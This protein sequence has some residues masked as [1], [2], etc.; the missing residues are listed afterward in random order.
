MVPIFPR[1]VKVRTNLKMWNNLWL[2]H[3]CTNILS[4][5]ATWVP[6][7]CEMKLHCNCESWAIVCIEIKCAV[8]IQ[9]NIRLER[10]EHIRRHVTHSSN[11]SRAGSSH[12]NLIRLQSGDW[13]AEAGNLWSNWDN[14]PIHQNAFYDFYHVFHVL[15]PTAGERYIAH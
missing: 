2:A 9:S 11:I 6:S 5:T 14:R 13:D 15:F 8:V 10:T 3:E 1:H 4:R 7:H 12:L